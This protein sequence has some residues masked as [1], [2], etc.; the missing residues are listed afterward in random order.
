VKEKIK[1]E[2]IDHHGKPW[3]PERDD[4]RPHGYV[5]AQ[6]DAFVTSVKFEGDE[7]TV[8]MVIMEPR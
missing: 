7:M 5:A 1:Y 8:T 2:L 4:R 3:K 6:Y